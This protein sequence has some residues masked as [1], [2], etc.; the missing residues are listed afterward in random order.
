MPYIGKQLS[1]GNYLKLDDISSS[2][3]GSTTTF[4]LTNGGSAYYPG[5][6]LSILVSVGGVIQEPESAYQISNDE[7]TFANAPTTQ[8]SFFCV[9][10][11][12]AIGINVPGNNTVNG[13]QMAK[14]FSYDGGLLYLNDTDNRVGINST[15]PQAALDVVG[16]LNV[17]GNISGIGGTLGG[18]L[19]G[20][21]YASSGISTFNDLLVNGD[22]TVQGDTTTLNTTL[23]NVELLRVSTASTLPAGIITQTGT[24]DILSL[25]DNTTEVFKVADG[26]E[27]TTSNNITVGGQI[28]LPD[29]IVHSGNDNLK[30][31]FVDTDTFT[32]ETAGSER[33]RIGST[34]ISTFTNHIRIVKSSGPLLELTTNAGSGDA[35]LRLSEGATGSTANGGGMFY[36]AANNKLHITCGTDSTTKRITINRDDGYVGI[37]T[38]NPDNLLHLVGTNT[39]AWPFTV[40]V[41]TTYAYTPYPHELQIQNHARD[42]SNSFAGIYFHPGAAADG[43]KMASARIAAVDTGD[44][45]SDLVFATRNTNFKERVRITTAGNVGIGTNVPGGDLHIFDDDSSARIYLTSGNSDDSSIYFG[46]I[47][48]T[49]TAAIRNDHSDNSLRL[50]GYNNKERIRINSSGAVLIAAGVGGTDISHSSADDLQIGDGTVGES[51][52]L[53]IYSGNTNNGSIYFADGASGADRYKGFLEYYHST[54]T[55]GIGVSGETRIKSDSKGQLAIKG[56]TEAFDNTSHW[57]NSL[58]LY[59]NT[60]NGMSYIGPYSSGGTTSL[61]FYAN[62]GG[63]AAA[64]RLCILG[65]GHI[66]TQSLTGVSFDNDGGNTKIFEVTGDG[67]VG[68]YGVINISGNQNTNGA[69]TGFLRFVN[70][71]NS[72]ASSGSNAGSK[73]VA[74]IQAY[75]ETSDS[76]AGDDS[77]GY[78]KFLTKP[79]SSGVAEVFRVTSGGTVN[80]GGDWTQTNYK[81]QVYGSFAATT[82]SFVIDHPT[83]EN[84]KLRYACLE[85]PENSVYVRGRSSDPVIELPDYWVG[86]VHDD[87]ITVN[88]TPIGNKNVWVESINNNSVTI[89]SDDSTEYFY[90]VF[91]ERKDVE[92]LEVEVEN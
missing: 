5:S 60:Q 50:Y 28:N 83:K 90:T 89:G 7:I 3:N 41:G 11:G 2:F 20:N 15:S 52:G 25:Y 70:R 54:D 72:N 56:N 77:G 82:K 30:L 38:D 4:S 74:G 12:D 22:L 31:R 10:L 68:E 87:S 40:N 36:S 88:V 9:V 91:A 65:G 1:N 8:D 81:L 42:S 63:G 79:E 24:G 45:N 19:V 35:I 27:V 13:T 58:N 66:V 21:V 46:R 53:T 37:G 75:V 29:S 92:K 62:S 73:I 61:H 32:V 44:Y 67:T 33:L 78:L 49:A 69:A 84:H 48:D 43:S 71:E 76:N 55:I 26:G 23:R 47:N 14:P 39:T 59:H 85:G 16:D 17:S 86:L 18:T 6:E 80:I 34:G 51:R 64:Q 57:D